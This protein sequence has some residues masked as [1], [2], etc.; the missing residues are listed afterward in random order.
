MNMQAMMKQA[1]ELQRKMQNVQTEMENTI[2]EG[3]SGGGLVKV[4]L[5]GKGEARST[6]IDLSLLNSEEKEVLE[7]LLVAAFNNAKEN[8]DAHLSKKM[9]EAGIPSNLADGVF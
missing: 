5:T 9:S 4:K 7:D 2:I 8:A 6:E 1:Q 3:V